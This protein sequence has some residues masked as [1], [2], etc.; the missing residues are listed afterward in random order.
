MRFAWDM[1]HKL[2]QL[3]PS[4]AGHT[5]TMQCQARVT[6]KKPTP[7]PCI[8]VVRANASD[9]WKTFQDSM[10]PIGINTYSMR[11]EYTVIVGSF[12]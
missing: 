12:W 1:S 2:N 11:N 7:Q 10:F 6:K 5:Q 4:Y 8:A 3:Q 9:F